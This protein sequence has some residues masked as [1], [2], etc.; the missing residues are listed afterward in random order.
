MTG[1][2]LHELQDRC[3]GLE[4][5]TS[6]AL[7]RYAQMDNLRDPARKCILSSRPLDAKHKEPQPTDSPLIDMH[8]QPGALLNAHIHPSSSPAHRYLFHPIP[9]QS[10][11][12]S[13]SIN[14][15]RLQILPGLL[16]LPLQL[17]V[18]IVRVVERQDPQTK[19]AQ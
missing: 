14:L 19:S 5:P 10:I 8:V 1:V 2:R 9:N 11:D 16:Y 18:R 17:H 7:V 3:C 4:K 15:L 13:I 6:R 12:Q